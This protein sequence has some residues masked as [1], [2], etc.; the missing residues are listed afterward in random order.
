MIQVGM[1]VP[2]AEKL[3]PRVACGLG[4][5]VQCILRVW[6]GALAARCAMVGNLMGEFL[7]DG[8]RPDGRCRFLSDD[9]SISVLCYLRNGVL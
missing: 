6:V 4:V 3:N 9:N 1:H 8:R 7:I 2:R 5:M